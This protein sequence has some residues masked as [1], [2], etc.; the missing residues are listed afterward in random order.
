MSLVRDFV[1]ITLA[2]IFTS[3]F[4]MSFIT[5]DSASLSSILIELGAISVRASDISP[6]ATDVAL[7]IQ[8]YTDEVFN[9][10]PSTNSGGIVFNGENWESLKPAT[11][12]ANKGRRQGGKI[13]RDTGALLN[14]LQVNGADN[15][16]QS[17]RDFVEF[18]TNLPQ[19]A[20]NAT[21]PF[22]VHTE[23]QT[24]I[25]TAI[26]ESYILDGI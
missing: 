15:I 6:A 14:S 12:K 17:G 8:S 16:L 3:D 11:L 10:A 23:E 26:L 7:G 4:F 20:N 22:L 5:I 25:I 2:P 13:L 1:R 18:G 24:K 21:R 19:A 9:S